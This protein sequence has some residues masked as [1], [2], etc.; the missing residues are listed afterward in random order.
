MSVFIAGYGNTS[1]VYMYKHLA[2]QKHTALYDV[3]SYSA[4]YWEGPVIAIMADIF[5]V[6]LIIPGK[7]HNSSN[8]SLTVIL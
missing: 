6:F 2:V 7:C 4:S 1:E 5:R 8:S 3:I